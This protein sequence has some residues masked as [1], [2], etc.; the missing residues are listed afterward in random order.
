MKGFATPEGTKRFKDRFAGQTS[1]DFYR[2]KHD[3]WFSSIGIGSYLG[4]PD[5]NTDKLYEAAL[6]ESVLSGVNVIDSA[7]NYRAQ[8]SERSFGKALAELFASGQVKR[9]EVII[10]TKGG[11][12]PFDGS[13]PQ[14]A[15]SFFE[16]TYFAP[17]ILEPQDI[18][19]GCHAMTPKYLE[20]QLNRSLAN[21][22]LETVDIYYLHNPETQLGEVERPEFLD[23]TRKAF[24]WLES[25]VKEGK[26]KYYGTATWN[27]Y[28][29]AP[30]AQDYLS[31]EELNCVARE[32]AGND[33]HFKVIQ[34][35]YNLGMPE[36]WIT[37]N[38]SYGA[39]LVSLLHIAEKYNMIVMGSGS[40]MQARLTGQLPP[41][42]DRHFPDL[43]KSSQRALQFARSGPGLTTSLV[44]MKKVEHVREN[45]EVAKVSPLSESQ[46]L[47]IFQKN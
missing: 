25:K 21:L 47:A 29:V 3:L 31:L 20:D 6:K 4:D 28:R 42:L 17:G 26:I 38:Q 45:L 18:A 10:S 41:F 1:A 8:R 32:V 16:K 11:F 2:L 12:I 13:Y 27:G 9:D 44:G 23:R 19:Q 33:N 24:E 5:E 36:A 34:L 43:Q 37:A 40:L 7:I 46:L 35:P 22:G 39:N 14:D 30:Q 15:E